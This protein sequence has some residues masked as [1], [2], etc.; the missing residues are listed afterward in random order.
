[1]GDLSGAGTRALL[2]GCG[3]HTAGS[4]LPD[5]PSVDS[6]IID[7]AAMFLERSG[8][9][10]DRLRTLLDPSGPVDL[11]E[12]IA[13]TA[14]ETTDTLLLYFVGHG[15]VDPDG[16]LYLA[17]S[18]SGDATSRRPWLRALP[19]AEIVAILRE[20]C[21]AAGIIIVLDCCFASRAALPVVSAVHAELGRISEGT[22]LLASSAR[23]ERA[24]APPGARH[25][26]FTGRLIDLLDRGDADLPPSITVERLFDHL[27][28]DLRRSGMPRPRRWA[29]GRAG[30][31]ELSPNPSY[32]RPLVPRPTVPDTQAVPRPDA[33]SPDAASPDAA[34][35]DAASPGAASPGGPTAAGSPR[36]DSPDSPDSIDPYSRCPYPGLRPFEDPRFFHG[37]DRLVTDAVDLLNDGSRR[38]GPVFVLGPSGSG[39]SSL[40]RAGI[41]PAL[42]R[43]EVEAGASAGWPALLVSIDDDPLGDLA[44][45]FE[46]VLDLPAGRVRERLAREPGSV[47][48]FVGDVFAALPSAGRRRAVVA[49]DQFENLFARCEDELARRAFLDVLR[50]LVSPPADGGAPPGLV[51]LAMRS[52]FYDDCLP[53]TELVTAL[54]EPHLAVGPMREAELREAIETPAAL[55]GLAVEPGL[56][57]LVLR[58]MRADRAEG[59]D[60]GMLPLLSHAL[61]ATWAQREGRVLTVA[62]YHATGGL[63]GALTRTADSIVENLGEPVRP[64]LRR[65][66]IDLVRVGRDA[67]AQDTRR[68]LDAAALTTEAGPG[69][70]AVLDQLA[71]ARIVTVHQDGVEITHD[72]LLEAWSTLRGWLDEDRA[73]ERLRQQ[74]TG[75]ADAWRAAGDRR[76]LLYR[77][78]TLHNAR[79][80]FGQQPP[81]RPVTAQFLAAATRQ[82]S[83]AARIRRFVAA[84]LVALL[85]GA[86]FAAAVAVNGQQQARRGQLEAAARALVAKADAVRDADPETALLL[87]IAADDLDPASDARASL[88]QN[89]IDSPF[90]GTFTGGV[91]DAMGFADGGRTLVATTTDRALI[92]WDTQPGESPVG[93]KRSFVTAPGT[94]AASPV[95]VRPETGLALATDATDR[96]R[97]RLWDVSTPAG[98]RPFAA[99][100]TPAD[101]GLPGALL[102]AADISA[103]GRRVAISASAPGPGPLSWTAR[104]GVWDITDPARPRRIGQPVPARWKATWLT[105]GGR[106]GERLATATAMAGPGFAGTSRGGLEVFDVAPAQVKPRTASI[107]D[108]L[109]SGLALS[110]DGTTIALATSTLGGHVTLFDITKAGMSAREPLEDPFP[111]QALAFSPDGSKLAAGGGDVDGTTTVWDLSMPSAPR[112]SA[113]LPSPSPVTLAVFSPDGLNLVTADRTGTRRWDLSP[114]ARVVPLGRTP[115]VSASAPAVPARSAVTTAPAA[116]TSSMTPEPAAPGA[117]ASAGL[118]DDVRG[119]ISASIADAFGLLDELPRSQPATMHAS[120]LSPRGD[121]LAAGG[122]TG[123]GASGEMTIRRRSGTAPARRIV[124]PATVWSVSFSPDGRLVAAAMNRDGLPS[125]Q[126]TV[127]GAGVGGGLIQLYD[128]S[129]PSRLE[130]LGAPLTTTYPAWSLT[131]SLDGSTLV[132][133][134]GQDVDAG[135]ATT[136][137]GEVIRWDLSAPARPRR[138]EPTTRSDEPVYSVAAAPD[139]TIAWAAGL[140]GQSIVSLASPSG[141]GRLT[142]RSTLTPRRFAWS[143]AFTPDGRTLAVGT[144]SGVEVDAAKLAVLDRLGSASG[145][146]APEPPV[147]GAVE[148]WDVSSRDNQPRPL[149]APITTDGAVRSVVIDQDGS[150]LAA[151]L[152]NAEGN[153]DQESEGSV[154][155]W[156]ISEPVNPRPLGGSLP[157]PGG[158]LSTGLSRDG[159]LLTGAGLTSDVAVWDVRPLVELRADA[160]T[161]ACGLTRRGL[162]AA[163]WASYVPDLPYRRTCG[164]R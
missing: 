3:R 42:A 62:G 9:S 46:R 75:D 60:A 25:T 68:R 115:A 129:D 86:L 33:A 124:T 61:L 15:L 126:R 147:P 44:A 142:I 149:G 58:E 97:L 151:G 12:A 157:A 138:I 154:A 49:V 47:R 45:S 117:S 26:A 13:E 64:I 136:N 109:V 137:P 10:A 96:S 76:D 148:L 145:T 5:L 118:S 119:R 123:G 20:H 78:E 150:T 156:D 74:A 114:R 83:R 113:S 30:D 59:H 43:G 85:L 134:T 160:A 57:E 101:L 2:V 37:R 1:M 87:G 53:H 72:A 11:A 153:S 99:S 152:L 18:A 6:T 36:D 51:L 122:G 102:G 92:S 67:S 24:L 55:A 89:I 39:K 111:Y 27:D 94:R 131:F 66:M 103:D 139:G 98:P 7:L 132:A 144:D 93:A 14:G 16:R 80:A 28:A 77:G 65:I 23:D 161:V 41:L 81:R 128:V 79:A 140:A 84:A 143:V 63:R 106:D 91:P 34:S 71:Q 82:Q 73:D 105:F 69:A 70:A 116:S 88:R 146:A 162:T 29:A 19:F 54:T 31:T 120:A 95:T 22:Y 48:A 125:S 141:T 56:V 32:R 163:E 112:R 133:G 40:L 158:V 35:P 130:P 4:T 52:D 17:T 104:I 159:R 100:W 90:A 121:V 108:R 50:E 110:A 21:S 135:G 8:L 155:L 38:P 164:R 127:A 107:A